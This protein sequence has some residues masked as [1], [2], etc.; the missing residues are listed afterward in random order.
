LWLGWY[1]A[2]VTSR[3]LAGGVLACWA[4]VVWDEMIS[5]SRLVVATVGGLLA[6]GWS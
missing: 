6:W 3:P 5:L 2:V 1:G 4:A